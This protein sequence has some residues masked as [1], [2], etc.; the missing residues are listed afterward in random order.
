MWAGPSTG[1]SD[2]SRDGDWHREN[3]SAG[4]TVLPV[5]VKQPH[6]GGLKERV[7]N[8]RSVS[9]NRMVSHRPF[10]F[11]P[12][13]CRAS[14]ASHS[15]FPPCRASEWRCQRPEQRPFLPEAGCQVATPELTLALR[16]SRCAETG[17]TRRPPAWMST[18]N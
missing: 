16:E 12:L 15:L 7:C 2:H 18:R 6:R 13:D 9:R 10:P 1:L 8:M 14:G 17:S 4:G 5:A 11:Q 3:L